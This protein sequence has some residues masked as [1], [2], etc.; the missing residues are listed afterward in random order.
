AQTL[1]ADGEGVPLVERRALTRCEVTYRVLPTGA[2]R[3]GATLRRQQLCDRIDQLAFV[4]RLGDISFGALAHA[5]DAV[6]FLILGR[7]QH[8]RDVARLGVLGDR[9][10]GLE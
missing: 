3:N 10:R 4:D 1:R 9:A 8:D 6:G 7:D 5:P 2:P